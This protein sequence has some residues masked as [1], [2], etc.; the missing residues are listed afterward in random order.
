MSLL[1]ENYVDRMRLAVYKL[2]NALDDLA[3]LKREYTARDL[4]TNLNQANDFKG[5]NL[6]VTKE[7]M[8]AAVGSVDALENFLTSNFHYGNLLKIKR[9]QTL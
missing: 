7:E 1:N 5:P 9:T 4:G 3:A 8:V 6:D 2:I